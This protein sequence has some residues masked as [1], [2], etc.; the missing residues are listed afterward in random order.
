MCCSSSS[1][2]SVL[3]ALPISRGNFAGL[4][5]GP[6]DHPCRRA[7]G[8]VRLRG[9]AGRGGDR[10]LDRLCRGA[11]LGPDREQPFAGSS[12]V[13]R[14]T[15]TASAFI[16]RWRAW[17]RLCRAAPRSGRRFR[18]ASKRGS[19]RFAWLPRCFTCC[20]ATGVSHRF[21]A[22]V[23]LGV[24]LRCDRLVLVAQARRGSVRALPPRVPRRV[25]GPIL[26]G[27]MSHGLSANPGYGS[28]AGRDR[29][30]R[31][32]PAWRQS[33]DRTRVWRSVWRAAIGIRA[34]RRSSNRRRP[35][36]CRTVGRALV[37]DGISR[38]QRQSHQV[39]ALVTAD[40]VLAVV[41]VGIWCR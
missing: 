6:L 7:R 33:V 18:S 1:C 35:Q 25:G 5:A 4:H 15:G 32:E 22:T 3:P 27:T 20:A 28:G 41:L 11:R 38:P 19:S 37:V 36:F 31:P 23:L 14:R 2:W 21:S 12:G 26:S 40:R 17:C 13:L 16:L 29:P 34:T 24:A 39:A 9:R 8:S 10:G 30:H